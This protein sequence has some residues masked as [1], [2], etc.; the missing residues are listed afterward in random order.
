MKIVLV[1]V[2]WDFFQFTVNP[3]CRRNLITR[4]VLSL[5]CSCEVLH[6]IQSSIYTDAGILRVWM[7]LRT[8]V[9]IFVKING[10]RLSPNDMA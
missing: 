8:S 7:Y 2:N 10:P 9:I 5:S 3:S 1:G 6:R 4:D